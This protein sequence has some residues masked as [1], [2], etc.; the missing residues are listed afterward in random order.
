MINSIR[1]EGTGATD[2]AVNFIPLSEKKLGKVRPIL[3]GNSRYE[4]L[5]HMVFSTLSLALSIE[6]IHIVIAKNAV[7]VSHNLPIR[8]SGE[9]RNPGSG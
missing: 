2:Q 6:N 8:H 9:N 4:C 7:R 1:I 3:T 5:F